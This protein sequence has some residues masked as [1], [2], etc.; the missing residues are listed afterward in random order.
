MK[1]A[2]FRL[3]GLYFIFLVFLP[4]SGYAYVSIQGGAQI[5]NK[6][7]RAAAVLM[8]FL[9]IT[10]IFVQACRLDR[11]PKSVFALSSPFVYGIFVSMVRNSPDEY[12][13]YVLRLVS[14]VMIFWIAY[15]WAKNSFGRWK[16]FTRNVVVF[17]TVIYLLQ[18]IID[19]GM[20]RAL[21]MNG[22]VRLPGSV[23]SPP[24]Y[25]SVCMLFLIG[26]IYFLL[27]ERRKI[28]LLLSTLLVICAF[29]TGTRAIAVLCLLLLGWGFIDH[30]RSPYIKAI[31]LSIVVAV[32]P[33]LINW[34]FF[35]TE[36]GSRIALALQ[37]QGNDTSTNFRVMIL[38]TY[39]S[40]ITSLELWFG[41]GIGGFP[42]WFM[43]KTG[44]QDVGPHFEFLWAL[45][46]LGI[47]GSII[48][49]STIIGASWYFLRGSVRSRNKTDALFICVL[50]FAQQIIFQFTNPLYFYQLCVPLL[51]L[52]GG[53]LGS[54]QHTT[55][56]YL[57]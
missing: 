47:A 13:S 53:L 8:L 57:N 14:F 29:F 4:F 44:I 34:I 35:S 26:N 21:T 28:Y 50:M 56:K 36:I 6:D 2:A 39:F 55:A 16:K 25:A 40:R 33:L 12:L 30:Y 51:F 17:S 27:K 20:S 46:E 45:S 32:A 19:V 41:L 11:V 1:V 31:V 54:A 52:L 3:L 42:N 23:G 24:G 48:Y 22:A 5:I 9:L 18:A 7:L 10:L 43:D 15:L 49:L 38:T 37:D